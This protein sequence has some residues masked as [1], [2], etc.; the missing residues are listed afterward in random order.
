MYRVCWD[1][2]R[3]SQ[4][5]TLI[6]ITLWGVFDI[7]HRLNTGETKT[8]FQCE[9]CYADTAFGENRT[10]AP[11]HIGQHLFIRLAESAHTNKKMAATMST[12]LTRFRRIS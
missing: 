4:L 7:T 1:D 3:I 11:Q 9:D 6:D 2:M 10:L 5:Y 12:P 8:N